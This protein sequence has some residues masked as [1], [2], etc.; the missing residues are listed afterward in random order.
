[1]TDS[2]RQREIFPI[3]ACSQT[4]LKL[5]HFQPK[6]RSHTHGRRWRCGKTLKI[7]FHLSPKRR[8]AWKNHQQI[9]RLFIY[10][11]ILFA[12]FGRR[13]LTKCSCPCLHQNVSRNLPKFYSAVIGLPW[14]L[15]MVGFRFGKRLI[16]QTLIGAWKRVNKFAHK[17][18]MLIR[19]NSIHAAVGMATCNTNQAI[20]IIVILC[21]S[22]P[23][24]IYYSIFFYSKYFI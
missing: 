6:Q 3:F 20:I 21:V 24:F 4:K 10:L 22:W 17:A 9:V 1:M 11:L 13:C 19:L 14:W 12:I 8:S 2:Q 5:F 18:N 16:K 23:S 15:D 7:N